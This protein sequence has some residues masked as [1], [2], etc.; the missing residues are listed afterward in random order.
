MLTL[1]KTSPNVQT[2]SQLPSW[3]AKNSHV[4]ASF[5]LHF[6]ALTL[7]FPVALYQSLLAHYTALQALQKEHKKHLEKEK[8]LGDVLDSLR[9]GYNPNYQD[10]AVLEAVRG[11]ESLAGLPHIND[12]RKGE[13][14]GEEAQVQTSEVK[15]EEE[16]TWGAE[17]IEKE[18]ER[19]LRA[20]HV[21]LLL[22]H[23]KVVDSSP[24]SLRKPPH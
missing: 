1:F 21:S 24:R 6:P 10:M 14:S 18:I 17:E 5:H 13:E 9:T 15:G 12:V 4:T 11:W 22:E 7:V 23:D 20:D 16:G 19:L 3:N 2:R 8:V